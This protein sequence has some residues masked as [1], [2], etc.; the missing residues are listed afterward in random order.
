MTTP[1]PLRCVEL[2]ASS[3]HLLF[4]LA[5]G[6][7]EQHEQ[8]HADAKRVVADAPGALAFPT[9][10]DELAEQLIRGALKRP[11]GVL[12]P[13]LVVSFMKLN[14]LLSQLDYARVAAT[15]AADQ[16]AIAERQARWTPHN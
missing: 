8:S 1:N 7:G 11:P 5:L 3:L 13:E 6:G 16:S 15:A 2:L 12:G 14:S 4:G 9:E 10:D